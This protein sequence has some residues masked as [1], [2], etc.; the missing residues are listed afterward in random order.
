MSCYVDLYC[1]DCEE[2]CGLELNRAHEELRKLI[3]SKELIVSMLP[4]LNAFRDAS[5]DDN[6]HP[7]VLIRV[8][9]FFKKHEGH[10]VVVRDE[11][12]RVHGQLHGAD[13]LKP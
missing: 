11:Y 3:A 1:Q 7:L 6:F 8:V 13:D 4:G 10:E 2:E 5:Y 12:G 9:G